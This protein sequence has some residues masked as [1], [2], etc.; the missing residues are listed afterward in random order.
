MRFFKVLTVLVFLDKSEFIFNIIA[1]AK[2]LETFET[3][4]ITLA[5]FLM[6]RIWLLLTKSLILH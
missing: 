2:F 4:R 5:S 3:W 6:I 1:D